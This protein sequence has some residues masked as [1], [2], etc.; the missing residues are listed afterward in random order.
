M[1]NVQH[2]LQVVQQGEHQF[3]DARLIHKALRSKRQFADW[4]KDKIVNSLFK[5]GQ[6]YFSQKS[7]KLGVGRKGLDYQI[8]SDT[9]KHLAMME[10]NEV[11][12]EIRCKIIAKEKELRG[13]SQLPRETQLFKG[14]KCEKINGRKLYPYRELLGKMGYNNTSGGCGS[15]VARYQQHFVKMGRD[16]FMTEEFALHLH[17]SKQCWH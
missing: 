5:E 16:W 11:G 14:V 6:D 8:T 17:H 13:I 1:L 7:E 10:N 9:A 2:E 3:Y 4:V 12:Y 15:R